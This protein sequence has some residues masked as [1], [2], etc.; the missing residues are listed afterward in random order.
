MI[1]NRIYAI[2]HNPPKR[3]ERLG[4]FIFEKNTIKAVILRDN[5]S[6]LKNEYKR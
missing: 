3:L 5:Y 1:E 6:F 2:E 4:G